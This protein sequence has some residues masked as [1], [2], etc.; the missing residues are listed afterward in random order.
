ME[1]NGP[2]AARNVV[3]TDTLPSYT[4]LRQPFVSPFGWQCEINPVGPG[5]TQVLCTKDSDM[6]KGETAIIALDVQVSASTPDGTVITNTVSISSDTTDPNSADNTASANTTVWTPTPTPTNTPTSTPTA[7]PTRTPT[8]TPTPTPT[9]TPIA[10]ITIV[11]SGTA[12]GCRI[13]RS[14]VPYCWSPQFSLRVTNQGPQSVQDVVVSDTLPSEVQFV[15][16]RTSPGTTCTY[17]ATTRVVMCQVE[18]LQVGW[19]A[20]IL[21][22]LSLVGSPAVITNC[23]QVSSTTLDPDLNNNQSCTTVTQIGADITINKSATAESGLI[24]YNLRVTN[25]GPGTA[26]NV[27]VSDTLPSQVQYVRSESGC[28]FDTVTRVVTCQLRFVSQ[29]ETFPRSIWVTS[30]SSQ[31][32]TNCAQVSSTNPDPDLSNNQSC[33]TVATGAA[34]VTI[35]KSALVV[36]GSIRYNLEVTNPGLIPAQSVVISDTLP[37]QV[38]YVRSLARQATCT[39]DIVTRVVTCRLLGWLA[40]GQRVTVSI[41]V[42]SSSSQPFTNCAQ[43]NSTTP[44]PDPSNN[45]SCITLPR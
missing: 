29:G 27:V 8:S 38:R 5:I 25:R 20:S 14:G 26:L 42:T 33:I 21:I 4:S 12:G 13:L 1:N 30:S 15:S 41:I 36:A 43:V 9:N 22:E 24:R 19:A 23:A 16:T 11:K 10:D 17:N 28:T 39:Y 6:P 31:P 2:D 7:T 37:S 18:Q 3:V 34:N 45:Q 40:V 44:D 32:F 35:S